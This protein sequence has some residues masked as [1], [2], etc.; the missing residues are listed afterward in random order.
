MLGKH[1]FPKFVSVCY[2]V[3][4]DGSADEI[5]ATWYFQ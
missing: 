3:G 4:D 2:G 1:V 5:M